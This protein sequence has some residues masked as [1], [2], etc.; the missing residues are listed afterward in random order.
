MEVDADAVIGNR[1]SVWDIFITEG[2]TNAITFTITVMVKGQDQKKVQDMAQS[3][4]CK[5]FR[6]SNRRSR[7]KP[8]SRPIIT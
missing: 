5:V 3:D 8:Y 4:R 2:N 1:E 6:K 7:Q